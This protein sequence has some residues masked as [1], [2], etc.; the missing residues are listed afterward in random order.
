MVA[1]DEIKHIKHDEIL[2]EEEKVIAIVYFDEDAKLLG[3]KDTNVNNKDKGIEAVYITE[4][5]FYPERYY[6]GEISCIKR[7]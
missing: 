6:I 7:V 3:I 4:S 5:G 2:I 1:G